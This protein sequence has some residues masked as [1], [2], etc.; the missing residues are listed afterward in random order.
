VIRAEWAIFAFGRYAVQP[1]SLDYLFRVKVQGRQLFAELFIF[2]GEIGNF[3]LQR[4]D[5]LVFSKSVSFQKFNLFFQKLDQ[6]FCFVVASKQF[7]EILEVTKCGYDRRDFHSHSPRG[8]TRKLMD[9]KTSPLHGI[10]KAARRQ[11][12]HCMQA[13]ALSLLIW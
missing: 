9:R 3:G 6:S 5:S 2:L 11:D 13:I 8:R 1:A 7:S 12:S 4:A 10:R